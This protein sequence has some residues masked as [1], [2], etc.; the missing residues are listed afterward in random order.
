MPHSNGFKGAHG[1]DRAAMFLAG[2]GYRIVSRNVRLPGGEIDLVCQDGPTIV[3]VEVKARSNRRF[4]SALSAVD[5]KKRR[6]LRRL[7]ADY[8]Q[9][10]APN[11]PIRFDVVAMD[12]DRLT[13]HRN[14]F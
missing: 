2:A 13:L 1:E 7:A 11:A 9:I 8:V 14:A 4:G 3:F 12:G 5:A 10:V 6:T